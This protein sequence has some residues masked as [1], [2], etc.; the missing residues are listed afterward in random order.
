MAKFN[1]LN[2]VDGIEENP[3]YQILDK[4]GKEICDYANQYLN[5]IVTYVTDEYNNALHIS[6]YIL[7]TEIK[8]EYNVLSV[9]MSDFTNKKITLRFYTLVT[10]Q[11]EVI[12]FDIT[13]GLLDFDNKINTLLS[14]HLANQSFK[15]LIDLIELKKAS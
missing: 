13:N 6:L 11:T 15:F 9:D 14:T 1:F 2:K 10:K 3:I 4:Y 8:Y 5:Y 12:D 7:A